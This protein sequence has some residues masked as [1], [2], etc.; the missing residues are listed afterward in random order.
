MIRTFFAYPAFVIGIAALTGCGGGGESST[1][2][3]ISTEAGEGTATNLF[4]AAELGDL[5]ALQKFVN[6]GQALN[7]SLI[8]ISEPTRRTPISYAVFCLKKKNVS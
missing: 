8:H 7:L 3:G 5:A 1:I 4:H 2:E 6:Q